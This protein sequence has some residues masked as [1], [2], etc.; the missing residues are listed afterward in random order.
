MVVGGKPD[1][2]VHLTTTPVG[3]QSGESPYGFTARTSSHVVTSG[4]LKGL[5][6]L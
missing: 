2:G 3:A 1:R 6:L 4:F 5:W